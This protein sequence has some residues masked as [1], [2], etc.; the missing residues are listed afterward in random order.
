MKLLAST[1]IIGL[2]FIGLQS[3]RKDK[4]PVPEEGFICTYGENFKIIYDITKKQD[5][6]IPMSFNNYWVYADTVWAADSTIVSTSIDTTFS[7]NLRKTGSDLW[8][9]LDGPSPIRNLNLSD[10]KIH[11]LNSDLTGCLYKS[12]SFYEATADTIF[13]SSSSGDVAIPRKVYKSGGIINTPAG[14]F[15]NCTVFAHTNF[16]GEATSFNYII[17]KP[18][19]GFVK[20]A[21]EDYNGGYKEYTLIAYH[22]E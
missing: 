8:W 12:M 20:Y 17:L 7:G 10:N 15:D 18:G 19:V 5:G 13:D 14:D 16:Y 21:S 1:L 22:I 4:T 11:A 3:C 9:Y 6:L 2:L